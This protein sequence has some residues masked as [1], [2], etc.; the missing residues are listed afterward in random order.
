[1]S[2]PANSAAYKKRCCKLLYRII[3]DAHTHEDITI[4]DAGIKWL[5]DD[6]DVMI[7]PNAATAK[8]CEILRRREQ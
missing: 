4:P 7:D 2:D 1:M 6:E 3:A 8:A 5:E